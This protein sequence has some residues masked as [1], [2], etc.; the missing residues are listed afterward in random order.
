MIIKGKSALHG[1]ESAVWWPPYRHDDSYYWL[2][3]EKLE[4]T[5]QKPSCQ[6]SIVSLMRIWRAWFHGWVLLGF[7]GLERI[8]LLQRLGPNYLDMDALIEA[9]RYV[10]CRIFSLKKGKTA[11]RRGK[12]QKSNDL[13]QRDQVDWRRSGCSQREKSWLTQE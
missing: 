4:L 11:F 8:W 6:L 13:L 12:N 10:H 1:I 7:M 5:V 2:Q 9:P 3:M